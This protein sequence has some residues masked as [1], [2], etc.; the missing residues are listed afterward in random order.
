[1]H[2]T[3]GAGNSLTEP[4]KEM[5]LDLVADWRFDHDSVIGQFY[6]RLTGLRIETAGEPSVNGFGKRGRRSVCG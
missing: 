3:N 5:T 2:H 4:G 1:M 6:V